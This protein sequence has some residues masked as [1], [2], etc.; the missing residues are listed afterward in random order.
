MIICTR[1]LLF[2]T[3]LSQAENKGT[4]KIRTMSQAISASS[5]PLHLPMVGTPTLVQPGI[6]LTH[7]S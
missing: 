6:A 3:C 1:T 4:W 2:I 7:I 5:V